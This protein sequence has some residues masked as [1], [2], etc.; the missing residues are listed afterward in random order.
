MNIKGIFKSAME[1]IDD[2]GSKTQKK[3]QKKIENNISQVLAEKN[4]ALKQLGKRIELNSEGKEFLDNF[5][6]KT[7]GSFGGMIE[8]SIIGS[9]TGAVIG[10]IAGGADENDTFIGGA[11]KGGLIGGSLGTIGGSISGAVHKNGRLIEN[12]VND[13]KLAKTTL[14]GLGH[15][16]IKMKRNDFDNLDN[17]DFDG[18][19][20][21]RPIF[22]YD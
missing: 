22:R 9:S 3:A 21:V 2:I 1:H 16:G 18:D 12:T 5:S 6:K 10:G 20:I 4:E 7:S 11:L 15:D 8:G 17:L 19:I 13:L 14:K